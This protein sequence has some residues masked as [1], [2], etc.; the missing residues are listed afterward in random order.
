[1]VEYLAL[2]DWQSP[3]VDINAWVA[4]LTE[5]CGPTTLTRESPDVNWVETPTRRLRGYAVIEA[6]KVAAINFELHS[7]DPGPTLSALEAAVAAIG[8]ELH[9]E[10]PDD[11][12][13][14]DD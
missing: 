11:P 6:G 1:M 8:W 7:L 13:D 9:A 10:D 2:P 14:D 3:P 4:C 5:A 12:D